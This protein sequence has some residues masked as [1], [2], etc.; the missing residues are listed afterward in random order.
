[1]EIVNCFQLAKN[2]DIYKC[3]SL[4]CNSTIYELDSV[5]NKI[6][7][8]YFKDKLVIIEEHGINI[9]DIKTN[10]LI[11]GYKSDNFLHICP[12]SPKIKYMVLYDVVVFF[13]QELSKPQPCKI[14]YLP[15]VKSAYDNFPEKISYTKFDDSSS[16]YSS[17]YKCCN[18]TTDLFS[19]IFFNQQNNL[20]KR[21]R[22]SYSSDIEYIG[23]YV[24]NWMPSSHL[25]RNIIK[26]D[27]KILLQAFG[28]CSERKQEGC[29]II[30]DKLCSIKLELFDRVVCACNKNYLV[31][32]DEK[33]YYIYD[34]KNKQIAYNLKGNFFGWHDE[35][36]FME[37]IDDLFEFKKLDISKNV[38][39]TKQ[40]KQNECCICY[41]EIKVRYTLIPCGHTQFCENC[42]VKLPNQTCSICKLRFTQIFKIFM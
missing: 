34:H 15:K 25:C 36:I 32:F 16:H 35:T 28:Y 1:M 31:M 6:N 14:Q 5:V 37:H 7:L 39:Q 29:M 18:N 4:N 12:C 13:V 10:N 2:S 20:W 40:I 30:V 9:F 21:I 11:V 42:I 24:E 3:K 19:V 26:Y 41:N 8:P 33:E 38:S 23:K 22:T 17:E 27:E